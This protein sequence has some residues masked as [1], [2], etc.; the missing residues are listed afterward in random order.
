MIFYAALTVAG[1]LALLV[2]WLL[3]AI[4]KLQPAD[5]AVLRA[6]LSLIIVLA[7]AAVLWFRR[8]NN[9]KKAEAAEPETRGA[10]APGAEELDALFRAAEAKLAA[11]PEMKSA[12]IAR[13]PVFVVLGPQGSAKTSS[14]VNSGLDPELLAGHIYQ[15]NT[16]IPTRSANFWLGRQV[17]FVEAGG[18]LLADPTAWKRLVARLR[19]GQVG[20]V[21]GRQG[22]PPRAAVVCFSCDAFLKPGA[23]DSVPAAAREL[24]N[25]LG[26]VS[27]ALGINLPT[28]VLFTKTD[29]IPYFHEFV[30]HLAER[31]VP[32]TVGVTLPAVRIAAGEVYADQAAERIGSAFQS[33]FRSLSDRR[34]LMLVREADPE[35]LPSVYQFPR[36]FKK[37]RK[38]LVSFLVELGRPSQLAAGPFLRGFYFSGVRPIVT[39]TLAAPAPRPVDQLRQAAGEATAIFRGG[40]AQTSG[41]TAVP[42]AQ[43]Q[44]RPQWV[45]L[46]HFFTKVL[47][48]DR[49][50]LAASGSSVNTQG[51]RKALFASAAVLCLLLGL[52]WV[53]SYSRNRGLELEVLTA[54]EGL[55]E[56]ALQ[57]GPVPSALALARLDALRQSVEKLGAY[58]RE[59]APLSLRWGLYS[60]SSVYQPARGLY[61]SHFRRMLLAPV[62]ETIVATLR[63]L[64]TSPGQTDDYGYAYDTLKAYLI[65]TSDADKSTKPFL[66]S[67][68]TDRW[69]SAR[70]VDAEQRRLAQGQFEFYS[71]E[72]PRGNPYSIPRDSVVAKARA[73]L[74]L[75]GG[76]DRV[77][78]FMIE[79]ANKS[80]PAENFNRRFPGTREV[81]VDDF[82]VPGA[83]TKGGWKFMRNAM[84][85]AGS[86]FNRE[87]WVVGSTQAGAVDPAKLER[88]LTARYRN[89]FINR[90]REYLKRATVVRYLD[91]KDAAAKL[92]KTAGPQSPL[93][94]VMWLAAQNTSVEDPDV[95]KAFK[96][97][98]TVMPPA[99][100]DQY[101]GPANQPYMNALLPLQ[102]SLEQLASSLKPPGPGDP[103]AAQ[104]LSQAGTAKIAARQL[105]QGMG[106]DPDGHIEGVLQKL[107]EDPITHA[108]ALLRSLGPAELNGKG[109]GLCAQMRPL[110]AKYPFNPSATS[111]ATLDEVNAIFKPQQ[112][113][114]WAFYEENLKKLLVRQ[115]NHFAV[116]PDAGMTVTSSFLQFMNRAGDFSNALYPNNAAAPKLAYTLKP[117]FTPDIQSLRI[118]VDGQT[119]DFADAGS[120][121][122]TLTWPGSGEVRLTGR[123]KGGTEFSFPSYDG[124]W[125]VFEFFSEADRSQPTAAGGTYEWML[126][127]G[128]Q[129][130]PVTSPV[131][132]Q[133]LQ[134]RFDTSFP[135]GAPVFQ[136]GYLAG[137]ACV[138]EIAR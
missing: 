97:L 91:L 101:I 103:A 34:P 93:L 132:G 37:V 57:P 62:Q 119:A 88:D 128:R 64:P 108:E 131:T 113:A 2:A 13:L 135:A 36:E 134:V 11:S 10:A 65:T 107:L 118:T 121:A 29:R 99:S 100:V 92:N 114:I 41:E 117:V 51:L 58:E 109:R 27:Q 19:P 7:L 49:D 96:P 123:F 82:D 95:Q 112:G 24:R 74:Q 40:Q 120:P 122:K 39:E 44:K 78:Q 86:Y 53:I 56:N 4:L 66:P 70:P 55:Q 68:L 45:F 32:E 102:G 83:F 98:Y 47:L 115:G 22:Q 77:Y 80:N 73:Y 67:V 137:L 87:Q 59:G 124:L 31:E 35:K 18:K 129:G 9:K 127:G 79:E 90:W 26:D 126:R 76:T 111:K 84:K 50:A 138:S 71:D 48:G 33:I 42:R 54:A 1:L 81:L 116:S 38:L 110:F 105:G 12:S 104:T 52:A 6:G 72:L 8:N 15:D 63:A 125:A 5:A 21:F 23:A 46:P 89:D 60:G 69:A 94:G 3:P 17:V 130:R 20:S 16:V 106:I 133:P 25:R 136:K 61:F 30:Q 75:F 43:S 14:V 85:N 28:Y